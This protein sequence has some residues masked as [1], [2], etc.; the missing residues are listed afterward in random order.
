MTRAKSKPKAGRLKKVILII[1]FFFIFILALTYVT[2]L[3][4]VEK[5]GWLSLFALTYPF[6]LLINV[7]FAAGWIFFRSWNAVFSIIAILAGLA[8]H[9][10]YIQL[11]PSGNSASSCE[12][13]IR[14]LSY[15]TRGLSLVPVG[16][17]ADYTIRIDSM[18]N[19]LV[20]LKDFPDIICLQEAYKGDMIAK[21][22]G[23]AHSYH[24]PKS[25]LWILSRFPIQKKGHLEGSESS[26]SAIWTDIKT[27]QGMLR[28]YNM[29]LVSNRITNTTEELIHDM[30]LQ[31]ENT[32][33]RIKFIMRRYRNTTQMR[34]KEAS[35]IH[36]HLSECD[37]AAV[38]AGDGNDPPI[39]HTYKVLSK[40]L[41]DSFVEKGFGISTT[42]ESTLPL[43]RIDYVFG[44]KEII[45]KDH[46]T[47][48]IS[49]SDHYPVSA[50]IC[51]KPKTGS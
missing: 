46:S 4:S 32:W 25:S 21:R 20:D 36:K 41:Q 5:W 18:Y 16:K 26:P 19:A 22:F 43:L 39:S 8:H 33:E 40:G 13:S 34:A 51:L 28:V 47:H 35:T 27:P 2:P 3:V 49:Y 1:N 7:L 50:G 44:T 45:F 14:L 15:N 31:N 30:D 9:Q 29:H 24:G 48:H 38:I 10:R 11:F 12:E 37:H 23:F 17:D 42:Y 6:V